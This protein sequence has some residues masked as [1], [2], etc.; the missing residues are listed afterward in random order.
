MSCGW[1]LRRF[2]AQ[3]TPWSL[4]CRVPGSSRKWRPGNPNA[5][6]HVSCGRVA[7]SQWAVI[8]DADTGDE[9]PDGRVGEIWLHGNNVCRGYWGR[10]DESRR[11]FDIRFVPA[12]AIPRTTS[13]KLARQACR[14]RYLSSEF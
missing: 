11:T 9:L 1:W 2:S 7:R 5:V 12:G 6:A 10:P 8:V 14:T 4:I 13:G 3:V